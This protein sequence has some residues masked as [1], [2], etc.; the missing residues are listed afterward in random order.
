MLLT[1]IK[2]NAQQ[3]SWMKKET[4]KYVI[5]YTGTDKSI[6]DEINVGVKEGMAQISAFFNKPFKSKVHVY[7][8]PDRK[9]LDKQWQTAWSDTSFQS[10][11]WMVAS[12]VSNRLDILSPLAWEKSACEHKFSDKT[13]TKKLI[14]HE[15][16]HVFHGQ[17]NSTKDFTGMDDLAWLVEGLATYVSGQLD[18]SRVKEITTLHE[19]NNLPVKLTTIW[20]GKAKYGQ[21]GSLVKCVDDTYGRETVIKALTAITN[22]EVLSLLKTSEADLLTNWK[23]SLNKK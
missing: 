15:L 8:F 6:V 9:S 22:T 10:Q 4:D 3:V 23:S 21:A 18:S 12:G 5:Y 16:T 14:A 17:Y 2:T 20:N 7:I 1:L 11:C 13:G 19:Q